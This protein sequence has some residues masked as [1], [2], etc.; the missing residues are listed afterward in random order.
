M[1]NSNTNVTEV[2]ALY[3]YFVQNF[4]QIGGLEKLKDMDIS[5]STSGGIVNN[6]GL[7]TSKMIIKIVVVAVALAAIAYLFIQ[8]KKKGGMER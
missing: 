2:I 6:A 5:I 1:E 4:E 8:S 7:N 3:N